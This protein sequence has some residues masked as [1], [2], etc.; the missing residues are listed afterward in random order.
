MQDVKNSFNYIGSCYDSEHN[1]LSKRESKNH[2]INVTLNEI[3]NLKS[4]L[5]GVTNSLKEM[6]HV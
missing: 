4:D 2:S 6:R 1:A 3:R 5:R